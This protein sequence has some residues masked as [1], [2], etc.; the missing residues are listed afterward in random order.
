MIIKIFN[1]ICTVTGILA[2]E[3]AALDVVTSGF[4]KGYF[5]TPLYKK[6]KW[7]GKVHL[8]KKNTF[9]T[10]LLDRVLTHCAAQG[11]MFELQDMRVI[12][13]TKKLVINLFDVEL[14]DYQKACVD[15]CTDSLPR[16][17]IH[18]ATNAG[19]T[20]IGIAIAQRLNLKT[21]WLSDS[22]SIVDQTI[23]RF[24]ARLGEP[25]GRIASGVWSPQKITVASIDTLW[26]RLNLYKSVIYYTC[27]YCKRKCAVKSQKV[28]Y[29]Y[30]CKYCDN[31]SNVQ[32]VSK[33]R[34]LKRDAF[35]RA[36]QN[37]TLEYFKGID[38]VISD[39]C[40]HV[41]ARTWYSVLMNIHAYYRFGLS[42]TPFDKKTASDL[43][44][45][46]AL[47]PVI[48]EVGNKQLI[49]KKISALPTFD[50]VEI[51]HPKNPD[52]MDVSWQL[53]ESDGIINNHYRNKVIVNKVRNACQ[54]GKGVLVLFCKI[55]HG[56][57]LKDALQK[58]DGCRVAML[59]G[60]CN[61]AERDEIVRAFQQ[62]GI[63]VILASTIFDEGISINEIDVL[64][65]AGGGKSNQKAIQRVGRGLRMNDTGTVQIVDFMDVSNKYLL[66]HSEQRITAYK[67]AGL[68]PKN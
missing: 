47:G 10:G 17:I 8:F 66:R 41:P 49:S 32:K 39:E 67:S 25:I 31:T 27:M 18:L 44:L 7:D 55:R 12:P 15:V 36:K 63:N 28:G 38:V 1:T 33:V 61:L 42:A 46:G 43:Q 11:Y 35:A 22:L 5:F 54:R 57:L 2:E 9:P 64:L 3:R 65:L 24:E 51:T 52:F 37:R 34:E 40:S 23:K 45:I 56:M 59:T 48:Y 20:E 14:R 60:A 68:M 53:A 30:T 58:V 19:K 29:K 16:G 13:P 26:S 6:H 62:G 4:A 50:I 21:L